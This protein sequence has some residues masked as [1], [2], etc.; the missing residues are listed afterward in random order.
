MGQA[1]FELRAGSWLAATSVAVCAAAILRADDSAA[2]RCYDPKHYAREPSGRASSPIQSRPVYAR[3]ACEGAKG[4]RASTT[5]LII[6]PDR[7]AHG[8]RGDRAYEG[9]PDD[10]EMPPLVRVQMPAPV[11]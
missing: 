2:G 10:P 6:F 7:Y 4:A 11:P 9:S 5:A 3:I 1:V 8:A